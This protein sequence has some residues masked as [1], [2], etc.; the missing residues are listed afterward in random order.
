MLKNISARFILLAGAAIALLGGS[1]RAGSPLMESLSSTKLPNGFLLLPSQSSIEGRNGYILHCSD[2]KY[3][4]LPHPEAG[5]TLTSDQMVDILRTAKNADV[6]YFPTGDGTLWAVSGK[7]QDLGTLYLNEAAVK[8]LD[9]PPEIPGDKTRP[10][11]MINK[12]VE[13]HTYLLECT[14]GHFALVRAIQKSVV[15]L[16]VQFVYQPNGTLVFNI[17]PSELLEVAPVEPLTE[18]TATRPAAVPTAAATAPAPKDNSVAGKSL[19]MGGSSDGPTVLE[20]Y[21]ASH[22]RQRELLIKTRMTIVQADAA[23]PAEIQKKSDAIEELGQLRATEAADLLIA[24]ITFLN[25]RIKAK[26]FSS[27]IFHPAVAALRQIGKPASLA[28]LKALRQLKLDPIEVAVDDGTKSPQYRAGLLNL[29][30][31]GVEGNEVAELLLKKDMDA[32]DDAHRAIYR[33]IVNS[34]M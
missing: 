5:Q 31:R 10:P 4:M 8:K 6:M 3:A 29:V 28:A 16:Q 22:L 1:A 14:D 34:A 21:L 27:D 18:I 33:Q 9:V 15:G 2:G 23:T 7:C 19:R 17:P 24:Q 32:A 25:P 30:I 26:E 13:G 20:P 12:I 11:G